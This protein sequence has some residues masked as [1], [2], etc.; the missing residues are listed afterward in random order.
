MTRSIRLFLIKLLLR[1]GEA[2]LFVINDWK[3]GTISVNTCACPNCK[4]Y[5][6]IQHFEIEAPVC[7]PFCAV[8]FSGFEVVTSEE[9][10]KF[11]V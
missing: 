11:R 7:C 6:W 8:K 9:M 5:Y 4:N 2:I 3:K 10:D 1:K